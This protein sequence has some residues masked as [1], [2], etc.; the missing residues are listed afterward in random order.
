MDTVL[1]TNSAGAFTFVYHSAQDLATDFYNVY[2]KETNTNITAIPVRFLIRGTNSNFINHLKITAPILNGGQIGNSSPDNQDNFAARMNTTNNGLNYIGKPILIMWRDIP[3]NLNNLILNSSNLNVSYRLEYRRNNG[4][5]VPIK[6]ENRKA[7]YAKLN[8]FNSSFTPL[9]TGDYQF[10]VTDLSNNQKIDISATVPVINDNSNAEIHFEWDFSGNR[11]VQKPIGVAADGVSRIYLKVSK[12]QGYSKTISS[13][14]INVFDPINLPITTNRLLGKL[15]PATSLTSYSLEANSA[16][17]TSASNSNSGPENMFWFWYV[18]PDDF[19]RNDN[20]T[21]LSE[22]RLQF[23]AIVNYTDNSSEQIDKDIVVVR[24]PLMLVHGWVGAPSAWNAFFYRQRI[25]PSIS[26]GFEFR[27]SQLWKNNNNRAITLDGAGSFAKNARTLLNLDNNGNFYDSY[28][29]ILSPNSFSDFLRKMRNQGYASNRVDYVSHSMGGCVL[30]TVINLYPNKYKP[31][32]SEKTEFKNYNAGFV[33]KFITLNTPH[34]GSPWADEILGLVDSG[35]EPLKRLTRYTINSFYKNGIKDDILAGMFHPNTDNSNLNFEAP[36]D[37]FYN[38]RAGIEGIKFSQTNIRNHL[39]GSDCIN[40]NVCSIILN[41]LNYLI[42]KKGFYLQIL[43]NQR[44]KT[45]Q[46]IDNYFNKYNISNFFTKGDVV[47]G[48]QSQLPGKN[49]MSSGTDYT[50]FN[51]ASTIHT[52][53]RNSFLNQNIG[54]KTFQLLNA[55]I[56]GNLF[57]STIAANPTQGNNQYRITEE[58][59][60]YFD[61][62]KI[63][64]KYPPRMSEISIDSSISVNIHLKDTVN[65]RYISVFFQNEIRDTTLK[66]V[67]QSFNFQINPVFT[68]IQT[69]FATAVYDSLGTDISHTDTLSV[70]IKK[71]TMVSGF[72]VNPGEVVLDRGQVYIPEY[73]LIHNNYISNLPITDTVMQI[74][75]ADTMVVNFL[76]TSKHF[77]AKDTG[78]T[79][80]IFTYED[81]VDTLF[82]VITEPFTEDFETYCSNNNIELFAGFIDSSKTYHWQVEGLYGFEDL[83]PDTIY[84]GI[85]ST[86]LIII[87]P[88]SNLNGKSYRCK[89]S[90]EGGYSVSKVFY[91]KFANKWNGSDDTAWENPLNWDCGVI[92]DGYTDVII[93]SNMPHMPVVS[94][95]AHCRS[96]SL[97]N[98]APII[99][100]SGFDLNITNWDN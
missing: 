3:E 61:T 93:Q 88:P 54:Q 80:V 59:Y 30:R 35:N 52:T 41:G 91:L 32:V 48:L 95:L 1:Q 92:P 87:N 31:S 37:A 26:I 67:N 82:I 85:D 8:Q 69:I 98:N 20:D 14:S 72:I 39:V 9:L 94:S 28:M 19:V 50:I 42:D 43:L 83:M 66:I 63:V 57:S 6:I 62:N 99:I 70:L 84:E 79:Y 21:L 74:V 24:P 17:Q 60:G 5:W 22:R 29:S 58:S 40:D 7:T 53:V 46:E 16:A 44:I 75:V 77:V 55:P 97:Q 38:L 10:R 51:G 89:I 49:I 2:A 25:D 12:K 15:M 100:T 65:L 13:V 90:D 56:N 86:T 47:V 76:N 64:I 18:A 78:S 11:P 27:N 4:T 96:I 45:C 68:D 36:T 71:D 73:Y 81:F 23:T 34:N 33:N